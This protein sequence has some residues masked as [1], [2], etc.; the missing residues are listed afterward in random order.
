MPIIHRPNQKK[1]APLNI[2]PAY[3]RADISPTNEHL[4]HNF[5]T[6]HNQMRDMPV[7]HF[8][9]AMDVPDYS[10]IRQSGFFSVSQIHD[11]ELNKNSDDVFIHARRQSPKYQGE[12]AG[13]KFHISVQ[14]EMVPQ[15]FQALSGLLF[16]EDSP[17]D[18]WKITDL[19]RA[20]KQARL[21]VGAQF[22]LYIKPDQEN[23]QYSASLLH[24]TRE[25]IARLESRLSEKGIIPGQCPDSD[26]HPEN[27]Q[28]LSYRNELRSDRSGSEVQ[29]QALREEPFY[30]LMTE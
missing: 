26:V 27:W 2:N 24:N 23:S 7:S 15:A 20:D 16:S 5:D 3:A 4:K 22:T 8:K 10:E 30:R 1:L 29:S 9:E 17:V 25:F 14:R 12:F 6:L 11:F 18:K 21:S 13:D 19:E 28:Y